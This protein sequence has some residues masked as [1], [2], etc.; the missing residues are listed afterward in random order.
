MTY[1]VGMT[2]DG[3][4]DAPALKQADVGIAMNSGSDVARDVAMIVLLTDDFKAIVHGVREGRLIFENL[5]KVIA[6]QISAGCWAE[7]LPVLATF[8]LGMPQPL[9]SFLMIMIS[10]LSDVYAGVALMNEP[11]EGAIMKQPPRDIK[12]NRLLDANLVVYSYLFYANC[13]SIGAFYNYFMYMASRGDTRAVPSPVPADDDGQRMFPA[14]YRSSQLIFA[15]NWELDSGNLGADEMAA[16]AVGSSLFYITIACGQIAH[17]LSLRRKTPYFWD[18]I[19]NTKPANSQ[20]NQVARVENGETAVVANTEF[21]PSDKHVLLRMWDELITSEIRWPIVAAVLGS[22][23]TQNFFN[24]VSV[25]QKYCGTGAVPGR[26]WGYAIGW[27]LLWFVVAEI[28]KWIVFLYPN[29][30][31]GRHAW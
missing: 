22:I 20:Y 13:I 1:K 10:C 9:S 14:G 21:V 26:F 19:M 3:V 15:W 17:L 31:I 4:N 11:A 7:L 2:G 28:R 18:A 24:Y 29:S 8:F 6:Y 25:F 5:R 12:K 16:S 30:Y 23:L 27:S